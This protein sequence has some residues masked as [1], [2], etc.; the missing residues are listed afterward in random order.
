MSGVPPS[1]LESWLGHR[2]PVK[3]RAQGA[4]LV[5]VGRARESAFLT[6]SQ[7][8]LLLLVQEPHSGECLP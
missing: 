2:A 4:C 5:H 3:P 7:V 6:R 8:T 1:P